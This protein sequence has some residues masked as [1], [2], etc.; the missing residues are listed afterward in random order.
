MEEGRENGEPTHQ[1]FSGK[2]PRERLGENGFSHATGPIL[3]FDSSV[4]GN[5]NL[6]VIAAAVNCNRHFEAVS[7]A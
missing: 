1:F 3:L 5:G 4:P 7:T 2:T 6:C